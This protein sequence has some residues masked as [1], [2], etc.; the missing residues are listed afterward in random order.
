MKILKNDGEK[1]HD[2]QN[3]AYYHGN[4]VRTEFD[5]WIKSDLLAYMSNILQVFLLQ[6]IT[7][8]KV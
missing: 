1:N 3:G 8:I 5:E 6:T 2:D 4:I 7:V